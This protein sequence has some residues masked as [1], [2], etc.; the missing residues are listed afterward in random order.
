MRLMDTLQVQHKRD[1]FTLIET[2]IMLVII[3]LIAGS[4]LAGFNRSRGN[5]DPDFAA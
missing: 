1:G 2:S 5:P 3:G 4:I